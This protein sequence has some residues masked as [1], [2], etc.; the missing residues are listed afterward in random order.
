MCL[1]NCLAFHHAV[2]ECPNY[3]MQHFSCSAAG[4]NSSNISCRS[5]IAVGVFVVLCGSFTDDVDNICVLL[6]LQMCHC[7]VVFVLRV[8]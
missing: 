6:R 2:I 4:S 5:A 8:E 3:S 7:S 1:K